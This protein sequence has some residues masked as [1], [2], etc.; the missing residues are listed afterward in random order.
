MIGLRPN[1]IMSIFNYI[2]LMLKA[3]VCTEIEYRRRKRLLIRVKQHKARNR[4]RKCATVKF[5]KDAPPQGVVA[6]D[7]PD[8]VRTEGESKNKN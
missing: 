6:S 1:T 4:A 8:D 3:I 7:P 2:P 5:W